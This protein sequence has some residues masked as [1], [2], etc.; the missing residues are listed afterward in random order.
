MSSSSSQSPPN[1]H[2]RRRDK[3]GRFFCTSTGLKIS[4]QSGTATM[5]TPIAVRIPSPTT[6]G[7]A[8]QLFGCRRVLCTNA[9][10]PLP[11]ARLTSHGWRWLLLLRLLFR[12]GIRVGPDQIRF[13]VEDALD[14][15]ANGC[16][17]FPTGS[18]IRCWSSSRYG[19]FRIE[20]QSASSLHPSMAA[21][22]RVLPQHLHSAPMLLQLE[23][24]S[25]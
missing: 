18:V 7:L 17:W 2:V 6:R 3:K 16:M 19:W 22:S 8:G 20:S 13:C 24:G 11:V 14:S 9:S 12:P 21:P 5:S 25:P 10:R 4:S 15:A 1:R 23:H